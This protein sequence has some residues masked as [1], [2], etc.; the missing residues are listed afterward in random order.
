MQNPDEP[1]KC[2]DLVYGELHFPNNTQD[3]VILVKADGMPTYHLAN[4][5]D[6]HQMRISHVLRGEVGHLVI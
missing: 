4:V 6:D 1:I 5:V 3:D 2:Q